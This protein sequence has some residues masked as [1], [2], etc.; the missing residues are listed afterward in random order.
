M[1]ELL[2]HRTTPFYIV[3]CLLSLLI[4]SSLP[5]LSAQNT[6]PRRVSSGGG[7]FIHIPRSA[8]SQART[9]VR[10][11][12]RFIDGTCNNLTNAAREE[13]GVSEL[14]NFIDEFILIINLVYIILLFIFT[15]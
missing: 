8:T 1:N 13:W 10:E 15:K 9:G 5:T 12:Y 2:N 7:T 6:R 4:I 11:I 3:L 14:I